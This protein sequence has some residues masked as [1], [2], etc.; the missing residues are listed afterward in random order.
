MPLN[1]STT[2][3]IVPGFGGRPLAM[4][5]PTISTKKRPEKIDGAAV[6][7]I[8]EQGLLVQALTRGD[9]KT[10]SDAFVLPRRTSR[11]DPA[12]LRNRIVP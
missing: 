4:L 1:A 11:F 10:G 12:C 7:L 6:S 8:Y 5:S 9:G 2:I 3:S